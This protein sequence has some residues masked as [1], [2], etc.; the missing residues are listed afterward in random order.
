MPA[1][2]TAREAGYRGLAAGEPSV[3]F[4]AKFRGEEVVKVTKFTFAGIVLQC[5]EGQLTVD[6]ERAPLPAMEVKD[7]EFSDRF[8]SVSTSVKAAGKFSK[9]G[10]RAEGTLRIKGDFTA[11]GGTPV[12]DCDSGKV[13]WSAGS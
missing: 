8:T 5:N 6:N 11:Q 3:E 9:K 1:A 12:T 13:R 4:V 7:N 10:K 2:A